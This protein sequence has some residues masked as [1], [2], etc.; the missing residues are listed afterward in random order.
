MENNRSSLSFTDSN[1]DISKDLFVDIQVATAQKYKRDIKKVMDS[2]LHFATEDKDFAD[3]CFYSL[4]RD[5]KVI[6]GASVRFAEL[7]ANCYGNLRVQAKIIENDGRTVT[8][9]GICWDL[10]NN[11][12]YSI[13]VKRS[14]INKYG[15]PFKEDMV[16]ITS[17]ACCAVAMRNAIFKCVPLFITNKTQ[18]AIQDIVMGAEKD[19]QTKKKLAVEYFVNKGV[20]EK[21]ILAL[22]NKKT[23]DELD[24]EDIFDLRGIANAVNDGDTT[25]E[26]AFNVSS[27]PTILSKASKILSVPEIEGDS[28][29]D[30]VEVKVE[31]KE[32]VKEDK[33]TPPI[34]NIYLTEIPNNTQV[35]IKKLD[36]NKDFLKGD[37]D[38]EFGA[39]ENSFTIPVTNNTAPTVPAEI[40]N[41]SNQTERP[42]QKKVIKF[43]KKKNNDTLFDKNDETEK[44]NGN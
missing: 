40:F 24:R 13:E 3:T 12:A 11:I 32:I 31:V 20:P 30:K 42:K 37:G 39:S 23:V 2:I 21:N 29:Y 5:G 10:E 33:E 27:K 17:N 41:S 8:A 22:F 1:K 34:E 35:N 18:K 44:Q 9:Q 4:K 6:R 14:I 15:E 28:D 7:I 19:F 36:E 16:V 25:L 26:L 38:L 43:G